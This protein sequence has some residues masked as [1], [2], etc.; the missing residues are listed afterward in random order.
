MRAAVF[1]RAFETFGRELE[2]LDVDRLATA[3]AARLFRVF[4]ALEHQ[5]AGARTLVAAR[6]AASG[7]WKEA[8]HKTPAAWVAETTGTGIGEAAGLLQSSEQ[9]VALPETAAALRRGELSS[10]QLR[11]LAPAA[12]LDP[13]AEGELLET[14]RRSGLKGLRE[15]CLRVQA[16]RRSETEAETRYREIHRN[17][18]LMMWTDPDG[19]GRVEARLTPDDL[20]KVASAIRAESARVFHRARRAGHR[21][22][23]VA[24]D[25]DAFVALV[26]G[27][28]ET[29]SAPEPRRRAK[30]GKPTT[31]MH[32][33]VD[34]AALR[35]G[36][37]QEGETC[38]IPGVGPVPLATARA[39]LGEALLKL[40]IAKGVDVT[41]ICHA[42]RAVPA[43]VRS[44]LEDRDPKC[45]VPGCDVDRRLEIDHY[46]VAFEN[47]GPT[48]L[49]NLARICRWHHYLK[50]YCHYQLL[51]DPGSWEWHAPVDLEHPTLTC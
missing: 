24:Y 26:T 23:S 34:L 29:A 39:E 13:G 5:M 31:V 4:T 25:A 18:S 45:V 21:E 1:E 49:W 51:G 47:D 3:D 48:E 37:L 6:A 27:T 7:Q 22:P 40:I 12:A 28:A 14:A 11:A 2:G 33:R 17:R 20:A 41:T 38:E 8:G 16:R 32:L 15:Q 44:A 30:N 10:S 35:R 19:V 42:G 50:T 9:L 43:A 46:K 36:S